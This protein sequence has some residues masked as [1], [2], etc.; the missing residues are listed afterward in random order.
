MKKQYVKAF[1]HRGMLFAG[2]G[3]VIVGI[4]YLIEG[5]TAGDTSITTTNLFVLIT[6][7]YLLAFLVAGC[8]VFYQIENWGLVKATF[9]HMVS[10]Y[11]TYLSCYVLNNWITADWTTVGIFSIIFLVGYL[12]IWGCI[13]ISVRTT[14]KKFNKKIQKAD[15]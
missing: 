1:L 13:Q 4:V 15:Q 5:L 3:P 14:A 6:T 12:I 2:F 10:L 7:S 11:V 9:F 8:S